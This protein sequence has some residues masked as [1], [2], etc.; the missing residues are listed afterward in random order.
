MALDY[1]NLEEI[2]KELGLPKQS[3]NNIP[4]YARR[5]A[6]DAI[7]RVL[8]MENKSL[9]RPG[10]YYI[11]LADL[12][13]NTIFNSKYGNG[14]ADVR[15]EWFHTAAIQALGDFEHSNYVTF[16]KTIGDASLLIF[17]SI[18]DVITWSNKFSGILSGLDE[19]YESAAYG[20]YLP[21][22]IEEGIIDQQIEDFK[23]K[24][25]RLVHVGEV[26]YASNSDPLSLAV[27][28]T[29]KIEKEFSEIKLGCTESVAKSIRPVI[30]DLG[31][32]LEENKRILI[33][34]EDSQSMSYY[35]IPF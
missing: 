18:K 33:A 31:Y 11:V 10:L 24:A 17:S 6:V 20:G 25:R 15:V 22:P 7:R 34:G 2:E 14:H 13:G 35:I 4:I 26:S 12:V 3:L 5:P 29:F 1:D 21:F 23:L 9:F 16:N 30:K 8:E 27:N 28:Q 32:K 19:E